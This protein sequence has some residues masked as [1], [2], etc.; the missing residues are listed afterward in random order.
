MIPIDKGRPAKF[1]GHGS[2]SVKL[3]IWMFQQQIHDQER[4]KEGE[5]VRIYPLSIIN[6]A[7]PQEGRKARSQV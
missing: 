1:S 5:C 7:S 3:R 4:G 2:F 6:S